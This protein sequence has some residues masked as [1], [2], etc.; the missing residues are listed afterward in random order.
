M[1]VP[2]ALLAVTGSPIRQRGTLALSLP[3]RPANRVFAGPATGADAAPA[4]RALV[5]ADIPDL[6]SL[7]QPSDADLTALAALGSTG[8]AVRTASNTWAQRTIAGTANQVSVSDGDGV[9]GNPTL[10]TPQD[11]HT[12]AT[13]QFARLGLGTAANASFALDA[14]GVIRFLPGTNQ[15]LRILRDT[16]TP[17]VAFRNEA[18]TLAYSEFG[19]DHTDNE[20]FVFLTGAT[21]TIGFWTNSTRRMRIDAAGRVLIGTSSSGASVLR[22]V[23]LPTSAAGLSAGDIWND[24]GTLKIA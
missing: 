20:F 16:G 17:S 13:P 2:S 14:V 1:E 11:I 4:F 24:S 9:S 21:R 7:Y 6:S 10:T 22:V 8:F 5:L 15:A 19:Y 18:D 12:G 23:G 3:V